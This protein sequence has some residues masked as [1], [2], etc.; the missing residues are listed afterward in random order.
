M[1]IYFMIFVVPFSSK[2]CSNVFLISLF[3][4]WC[5]MSKRRSVS[6]KKSQ[7]VFANT[8]LRVHPKNNLNGSQHVMRGGIRL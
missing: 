8:A 6:N 4:V 1:M 3:C 5:L 2:S 7:R